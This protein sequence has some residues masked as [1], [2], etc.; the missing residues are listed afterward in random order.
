MERKRLFL[1][2][3]TAPNLGLFWRAGRDLTIDYGNVVK[4]RAIICACWRWGGE[5]PT[6]SKTWD[7]KQND[8]RVVKALAQA[9]N[10]AD[11]VVTHNGN[12]F[13]LRWLRGRALY[14]E[15]PLTPTL[16]SIDTCALARKYFDLNS[17]RLD[18]VGQY[19][20]VGRKIETGGFDLWKQ[21]VM[22]NDRKALDKMVRYNA[23]DVT[24]LEDVYDRMQRYFPC[25]TL[26]QSAV[27]ECPECT[28]KMIVCKRR[29][30]AAGR[31]T[32]QMRCTE[33]GKF[34]TIPESKL[35]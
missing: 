28:G 24:L 25:R 15:I 3:E 9:V 11:E 2:I 5:Y 7:S 17:Y 22:R 1:D 35:A 27:R 14:H 33:C 19:L 29:V 23:Q 13:D 16:V 20:G 6:F 8:L 34:H 12:R 21:V 26:F 4:E 18:Y 32:V 30:S 10:A 31:K